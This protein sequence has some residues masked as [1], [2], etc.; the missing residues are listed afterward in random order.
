M[1]ARE[2]TDISATE[3]PDRGAARALANLSSLRALG[4]PPFRPRAKAA[5]SSARV[6][7]GQ[8]LLLHRG[9]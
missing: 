1:V 2:T 7:W 8:R 6:R 9:P 3:S 4:L 5:F